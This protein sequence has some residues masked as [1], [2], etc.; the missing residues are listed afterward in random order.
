MARVMFLAAALAV[1]LLAA[2]SS[3]PVASAARDD[4]AAPA[5]SSHDQRQGSAAEGAGCEG[6]NDE[7][8]CMMRRTLAAHTDYIYTQQHHN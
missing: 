1:L 3:A 4:P 5:V 8:E 7:D 2:A 6:A